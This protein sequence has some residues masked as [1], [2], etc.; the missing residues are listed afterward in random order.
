MISSGI[1]SFLF[2]ATGDAEAPFA[3]IAKIAFQFLKARDFVKSVIAKTMGEGTTDI[4]TDVN[5][6]TLHYFGAGDANQII[7]RMLMAYS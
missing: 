4:S 3:S 2:T 5:T 6:D 1:S 7:A